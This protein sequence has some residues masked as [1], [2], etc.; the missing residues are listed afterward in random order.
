[1]PISLCLKCHRGHRGVCGIPPRTI[2]LSTGFGA[3]IGGISKTPDKEIKGKP[4][5]KKPGTAVLKE[6]LVQSHIQVKAVM[7]MM[8]VL[9]PEL[10]EYNMLLDRLGKL[11]SLILQLNR[12]II[13][14]E[15]K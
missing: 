5:N 10:E 14:R 2:L 4:K 3:R 7:K 9:P 1:M 12:Q 6:M 8:R 15:S 13:S 11:E